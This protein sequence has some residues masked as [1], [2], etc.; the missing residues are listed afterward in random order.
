MTWGRWPDQDEG[1]WLLGLYWADVAGRI[2]CVGVELRS[3]PRPAGDEEAPGSPWR[4]GR[5]RPPEV[6]S[7]L[8]TGVL[9]DLPLGRIVQ[10]TKRTQAAFRRWWA[11]RERERRPELLAKAKAWE[12]Q[13]AGGPRGYGLQRFQEVAQVYRAAQGPEAAAERA[14]PTT[15]VALHFQVTKSTAAKWVARARAMGLLPPA[16]RGQR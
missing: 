1:P 15:A 3:V 13:H 7:V 14:K 2:E 12:S 4:G 5:G 9:R 16:R 10:D 11:G 8:G 6:P